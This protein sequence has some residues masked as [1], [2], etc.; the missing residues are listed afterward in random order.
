MA[1]TPAD[2]SALGRTTALKCARLHSDFTG[3]TQCLPTNSGCSMKPKL[4]RLHLK[5]QN[6]QSVRRPQQIGRHSPAPSTPCSLTTPLGDARACTTCFSAHAGLQV[7]YCCTDTHTGH[8]HAPDSEQPGMTSAKAAQLF[9]HSLW[10]AGP[11]AQARSSS[12]IQWLPIC[13]R[14]RDAHTDAELAR[15]AEQ[16]RPWQSA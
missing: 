15:P 4:R 14:A 13:A 9:R 2:A 10:A 11:H 3:H 5:L 7:V 12:S 16:P 8:V 6:M 1:I